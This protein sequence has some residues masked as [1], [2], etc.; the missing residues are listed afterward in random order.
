MAGLTHYNNLWKKLFGSGF[1]N[2]GIR[3]D[4]IEHVLWRVRDIVFPPRLKNI[5]MLCGTNNINRDHHPPPNDID[6]F[7]CSGNDF[8]FIDQSNRWTLNNSTLDFLLF[9]SDGLH[10]VEKGNLE[11]G[12]S[13]LKA[14]DSIT[15][16]LKSQTARKMQCASQISISI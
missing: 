15:I 6:S 16:G 5:I 8:H 3:G 2:L 12:K 1:I 10:L 14:I 4:C 9:Y 11:R 7:K 13:I